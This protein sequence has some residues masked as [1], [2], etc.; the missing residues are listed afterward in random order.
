VEWGCD[1]P[2]TEAQL[3]IPCVRCDGVDA[4]CAL[5]Q[6]TGFEELHDCPRARLERDPLALELF[7]LSATY[8]AALACAGGLYDQP[9]R[10]VQAMRIIAVANRRME[11]AIERDREREEKLSG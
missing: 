1:V 4:S 11:E 5:C 7:S 2:T 9:A 8:P 6:G 3:T 10:Y